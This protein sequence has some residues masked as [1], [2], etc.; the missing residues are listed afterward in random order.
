MTGYQSEA[1]LEDGL[2]KRLIGLGYAPVTLPDMAAM[3]DNLR[4]QLGKHNGVTL[5]D[6]EFAKVINHL[7]KGN[8][9]DK[10]KIL[11]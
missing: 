10:A 9:F 2:V 7:D 5:S 8:V 4:V 1:Q 6:A 3:R 11:R